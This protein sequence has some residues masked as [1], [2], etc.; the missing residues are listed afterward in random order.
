MELL[1]PQAGLLHRVVR[2]DAP[3]EVLGPLERL[4][5]DCDTPLVATLAARRLSNREI[6]DR[7]VVSLRTVDSHLHH[8]YMKLGI[9]DRDALA[10][11]LL[12]GPA[13]DGVDSAA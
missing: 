3:A 7:L 2:L 10:A 8:S 11:I 12:V 5:E 4:A 1:V 9:Q 13:G 6:A